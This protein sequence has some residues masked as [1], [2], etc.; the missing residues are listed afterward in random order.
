MSWAS[1]VSRAQLCH[2]NL[3]STQKVNLIELYAL[4]TVKLSRSS[5]LKYHFG[6]L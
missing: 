4:P 6:C 1:L 2:E 5:A 3:P